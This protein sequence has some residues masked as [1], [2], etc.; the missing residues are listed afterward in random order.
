M[1][2][3][4]TFYVDARRGRIAHV[5]GNQLN[6]NIHIPQTPSAVPSSTSYPWKVLSALYNYIFSTIFHRPD[7]LVGLRMY[8][9]VWMLVDRSTGSERPRFSHRH[10]LYCNWRTC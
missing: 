5:G 4:S 2:T 7:A 10:P 3:P 1:D 9:A 6:L 8:S